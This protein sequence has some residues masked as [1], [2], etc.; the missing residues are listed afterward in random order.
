MDFKKK[1]CGGKRGYWGYEYKG[2]TNLDLL[3]EQISPYFLRRV[4]EEVLTDLPEKRF[5]NIPV[6][7]DSTTRKTYNL[8]TN[9]YE[10]YL[11]VI[12][13]KT[14]EEIKKSMSAEK[15]TKLNALRQITTA[16][17]TKTAVSLVE[18]IIDTDEKVIVFSVY[19]EP[20]LELKKK[21]G[22][23]AVILTGQSDDEERKSAMKK[24]Q[25]DP[26]IKIF[27]GG[28]KAAG[29]GITLTAASNVIFIDYSWVPADHAQAMDRAHRIG[30]TSEAVTV[31]QLYVKETIDDY[32]REIL[33]KKKDIFDR[34]MDGTASATETKL[35]IVNELMAIMNKNT[36]KKGK[37]KDLDNCSIKE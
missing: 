11:E 18:D 12:K 35:N 16:G 36:N 8:A 17:K 32:M 3:R 29:V 20:L 13:E 10:L 9:N 23:E 31:Y 24:F 4:K 37:K 15:L 21:F 2:A 14:D 1:F 5:V 19:N 22:D 6:E 7:M 25:N 30:N 26:K 27:L 28:M 33:D 34:I